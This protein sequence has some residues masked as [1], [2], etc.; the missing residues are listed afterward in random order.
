V[1]QL[2]SLM[3]SSPQKIRTREIG[4][5]DFNATLTLLQAGFPHRSR[6][7][8][9]VALRRLSEHATPPGFPRYGYVLEANGVA[10]GVL[11]V[12]FSSVTVDGETRIRANRASWYVE[13][14]FRSYASMLSTHPQAHKQVTFLNITPA[15][16]TWPILE[17]QKYVRFCTGHFKAFAVLRAG[18]RG[19]KVEK[20]TPDIL[21]AEDLSPSEVDV[22]L[23][24]A[25][26][27]CVSV[28]CTFDGRR[29]PFVFARSR[30]RWKPFGL[31]IEVPVPYALLVYC[32]DLD[33]FVKFSGPLGRYL[34][35]R[36]MPMVFIESMGPVDGLI[37]RFSARGPKF[38]RGPNP[39]HVGDLTYT[40]WVMFGQ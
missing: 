38:F 4:P 27:G 31:P 15:R 21:P 25:S 14:A 22:L 3:S 40:E 6:D 16:H 29:H 8:W 7:H 12:I 19:A 2:V 24:H 34:A 18:P 9:L 36:A 23:A 37:G 33:D 26:Y 10:V 5:D 17:A 28:T 20:V 39:P 1:T 32:R 35:W 13:P 30:H 11:L